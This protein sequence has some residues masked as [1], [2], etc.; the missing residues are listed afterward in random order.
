MASPHVA[1]D[2]VGVRLCVEGKASPGSGS[3][4]GIGSRS[5]KWE[6]EN[7]AIHEWHLGRR[8]RTEERDGQNDWVFAAEFQYDRR[9]LMTHTDR[10]DQNDSI[11][12]TSRYTFDAAGFLD[13]LSH[14][15]PSDLDSV[16]ASVYTRDA[17]GR[18]TE[19][20]TV[21][22]GLIAF[23]YDAADQLTSESR[24]GTLIESYDW[25]LAGNRFH[26]GTLVGPGNRLLSDGEFDF[27]YDAEGR[28]TGR[29]NQ[30]TGETTSYSYDAAGR[31]VSASGYSSVDD[32][33]ADWTT[34]TVF[35]AVGRR[36]SEQSET[37]D[38]A[39]NSIATDFDRFNYEGWNTTSLRDAAGD[40]KNSFV[41]GPGIDKVLADLDHDASGSGVERALHTLGDHQ[42]TLRDFAAVDSAIDEMVS[43]GH[44]DYDAFGSLRSSTY[45]TDSPSGAVSDAAAQ[46]EDHLF[47]YT[48]R[49]HTSQKD[50]YDYRMRSYDAASTRFLQTDPLGLRAGDTNL[51]RYVGNN[52]VGYIDPLGLSVTP[53]DGHYVSTNESSGERHATGL[54]EC[55]CTCTCVGAQLDSAASRGPTPIALDT[56]ARRAPTAPNTKLDGD[57]GSPSAEM[58]QGPNLSNFVGS[59]PVNNTDP[60]GQMPL[61]NDPIGFA[62]GD[63][64]L[65]RYVGNG[66]TTKSDPSGLEPPQNYEELTP[67]SPPSFTVGGFGGMGGLAMQAIRSAESNRFKFGD[68][69]PY[70]GELVFSGNEAMARLGFNRYEWRS[71]PSPLFNFYGVENNF[72]IPVRSTTDDYNRLYEGCMGLIKIRLNSGGSEAF[73]LPNTRAFASFDAARAAQSELVQTSPSDMRIVIWAYQDNHLND[74]LTPFLLPGS[75]DEYDFDRLRPIRGGLDGIPQRGNL[76]VFDFVTVNQKPDGSVLFYE[77]MPYGG[78]LKNTALNVH[79]KCKLYRAESAGTIYFVVPI[80]NHPRAPLSPLGDVPAR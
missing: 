43:V 33:Q 58:I 61:S 75:R 63:S 24:D 2:F 71:T 52:A 5:D 67:P 44:R 28:R 54:P 56:S 53:I 76:T 30:T 74:D 60:T 69:T 32:S 80:K 31:L 18:I 48:G 72:S 21:A 12:L 34:T 35:D 14:G 62:A 38:A 39:G 17:K 51:Y 27:A 50:R 25:D 78:S 77:T 40:L 22:D 46:A 3:G 7:G 73:S 16:N 4:F 68:P 47:G 55:G 57:S 37:F 10:L 70:G 36:L 11:V 8:S 19:I 9:N 42:G 79:H 15:I 23:T 1:G 13:T 66:P 26:A 45:S 6:A 41:H 29:T 64:N 20:D 59:N 65:Y 49:E